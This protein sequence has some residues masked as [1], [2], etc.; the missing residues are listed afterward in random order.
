MNKEFAMKAAFYRITTIAIFIIAM[1]T[2]LLSQEAFAAD[3]K[4]MYLVK[5]E[6]SY[7]KLGEAPEYDMVLVDPRYNSVTG[8]YGPGEKVQVGNLVSSDV[9]YYEVDLFG[10][11]WYISADS[12]SEKKPKYSYQTNYIFSKLTL[13]APIKIYA[14]PS[15]SK[16]FTSYDDAF[17]Y[18]IGETNYWYKVFVDG[19]VGFIRKKSPEI[20]S[21]DVDPPFPLV[22]MNNL[23]NKT[24][25]NM[26]LRVR[27]TFCM[28]PSEVQETLTKNNLK[29]TVSNRING[30][31]RYAG[32]TT[33]S[34]KIQLIEDYRDFSPVIIDDAIFHE[35]GHAY[36]NGSGNHYTPIPENCYAE[37]DSLFDDFLD[38]RQ[39]HYKSNKNEYAAESLELYIKEPE[40]VK[41][42]APLTYEYFY[43]L[44]H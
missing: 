20:I 10:E 21:V 36:V 2:M 4:V 9:D 23:P 41:A 13:S 30:E 38:G 25:E 28:L 17:I 3:T 35:F 7:F 44:F 33:G 26:T 37:R 42:K 43:N 11:T 22:E 18:T 32:L 39:A 5:Q 15:V 27:Y 16:E 19:N 6:C 24:I 34:S 12:L 1:F 40:T 29:V 8:V 14:K 31:R